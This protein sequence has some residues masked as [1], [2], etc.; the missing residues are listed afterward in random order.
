MVRYVCCHGDRL[1]V[2]H[3]LPRVCHHAVTTMSVVRSSSL[4]VYHTPSLLR[5]RPHS[6]SPFQAV[7]MTRCRL[8]P[9]FL[10]VAL[11]A[12]GCLLTTTVEASHFAYGTI[13]W[14][15]S[16]TPAL[17]NHY[18]VTFEAAY[19]RDYPS[20]TPYNPSA[21]QTFTSS[22]IGTLTV[23]QTQNAG[24][25]CGKPS[26]DPCFRQHPGTPGNGCGMWSANLPVSFLVKVTYPDNWLSGQTSVTFDAPDQT[27][28][29]RLVYSMC[30]RINTLAYSAGYSTIIMSTVG[31]SHL[32]SPRST[33]FA[34]QYVVKNQA[35]SWSV[36]SIHPLGWPMAYSLSPTGN[37][38]LSADRP[39]TQYGSQF[40][41]DASTGVVGWTPNQDG[42]FAVQFQI[43]SSNPANAGQGQ[44]YVVLD[45]IF[46]VI[47][48]CTITTRTV[49][50]NRCSIH[51]FRQHKRFIRDRRDP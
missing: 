43:T 46:Q 34:R 36:P 50:I 13:S 5:A 17:P 33:S 3:S 18:V 8:A 29:L 42:L 7:V 2:S 26:N 6:A 39:S 21:G 22:D 10:A 9:L 24:P 28:I 38:A 23:S 30:C 16:A 40:T 44:S 41:L 12:I 25:C 32:Y 20:F 31:I 48:A 35:I 37:S 14:Q 27:Q 1:R 51:Q 19:R 4:H 15:L 49:S 11:A 45:T 47:D